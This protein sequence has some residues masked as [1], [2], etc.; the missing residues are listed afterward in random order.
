MTDKDYNQ[1]GWNEYKLLVMA[2][3]E[4]LRDEVDKL[5]KKLEEKTKSI[6]EKIDTKVG[7]VKKELSTLHL[8]FTVLKT[9][10]I[11]YGGIAGF[12]IALLLNFLFTLFKLK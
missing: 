6:E 8:D 12:V 2:S 9:K 4:G 10:A 3:L 11:V 1:N 5:D 7:E